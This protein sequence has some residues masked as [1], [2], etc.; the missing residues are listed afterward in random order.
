MNL[1]NSKGFTLIELIDRH[2]DHRHPGRHRAA[3]VSDYATRAKVSEVLVMSEP[4]KLAVSE[5]ASS[6]GG[7]ANVTAANSG[8][9]FPGATSY[10]VGRHDHECHRRRDRRLD[11]AERDR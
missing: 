5:T 6:L 7:L 1:K 9:S 11:G 8:Y 4:A 2:R 10:V 3:G